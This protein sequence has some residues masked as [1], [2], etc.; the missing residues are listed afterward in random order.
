VDSAP[1][2]EIGRQEGAV[3][4]L[5]R[6]RSAVRFEDGTLAISNTGTNEIR[7]FD[8]SGGYLRTLGRQG[9]GPG[10]FRWLST[11][12]IASSD[13]ILAFDRAL[14]RVTVYSRRGDLLGTIGA[15]FG[16][17]ASIGRLADG[18]LVP[19]QFLST[20]VR[21]PRGVQ[22]DTAAIIVHHLD[23]RQDTL[24]SAI[25]LEWFSHGDDGPPSPLAFGRT[26]YVA[27]AKD[28]VV[29]A[30]SDRL[31]LQW[32]AVPP[33]G[34]N[35]IARV[36]S[37]PSPLSETQWKRARDEQLANR[38]PSDSPRLEARWADVPK[39]AFLP[40]IQGLILDTGGNAWVREFR[41]GT[42]EQSLWWVFSPNAAPLAR[43]TVPAGVT[44]LHA[45]SQFV[46]GRQEDDI[47]GE[48]IGIFRLYIP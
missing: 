23:G 9:D 26:T 15:P 45:S 14:Q 37:Q 16:R 1:A 30:P 48:R 44:I 35:M 7:L 12:L 22:Q 29:V 17:A 21:R 27:T 3:F 31:E 4:Q 36:R 5:F 39:P 43:V 11:I 24:T 25:V 38:A 42:A 46:V 19:T 20:M 33:G 41:V 2:A 34:L 10:E 40:A 8:S 32:Y 6:A 28:A 47:N 18:S 13:S